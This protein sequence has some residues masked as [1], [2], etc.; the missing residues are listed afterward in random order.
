[1][2]LILTATEEAGTDNLIDIEEV[3]ENAV[4]RW[5]TTFPGWGLLSSILDNRLHRHVLLSLGIAK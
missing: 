2:D 1:M 3:T 5:L 4:R